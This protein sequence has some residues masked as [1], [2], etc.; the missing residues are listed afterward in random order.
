MGAPGFGKRTHRFFARPRVEAEDAADRLLHR[1]VARGPDVGAPLGEEQI[2]FGRPAAD[3][4][5]LGE[6]RDRVLVVGGE[7]GEVEL[8]VA[9]ELRGAHRNKWSRAEYGK[10][11]SYPFD[12]LFD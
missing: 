2:A 1:Q 11:V 12:N 9:D 4:L 6:Q 3:P 7:S 8:A 5:D 10:E